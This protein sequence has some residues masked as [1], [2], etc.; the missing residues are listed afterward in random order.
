VK[1]RRHEPVEVVPEA[2]APVVPRPVLRPPAGDQ[3]TLS[4]ADDSKLRLTMVAVANSWV[5]LE[6]DG[7]N[8]INAEVVKGE[9]RDFEAEKEFRFRTVGNAAGL[10]LTLN[11]AEVPALGTDGQVVK[12]RVFDRKVLESLRAAPPDDEAPRNPS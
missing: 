7:R 11:G 3:E 6:A 8:V 2:V 9:S 10:A 12:D 5:V 1:Y 4:P